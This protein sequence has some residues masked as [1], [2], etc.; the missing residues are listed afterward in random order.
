MF[1]YIVDTKDIYL[2]YINMHS[3]YQYN[4][5]LQYTFIYIKKIYNIYYILLLYQQH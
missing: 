2:L 3:M 5:I 1:G 4:T